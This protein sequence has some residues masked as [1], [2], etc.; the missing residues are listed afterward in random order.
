MKPIFEEEL[1]KPKNIKILSH[2]GKIRGLDTDEVEQLKLITL[3]KSI[4]TFNEEKGCAFST[5]LYNTCRYTYLD[6]FK[7]RQIKTIDNLDV[8]KY[9]NENI[10]DELPFLYKT[11][12]ED[13]FVYKYTIIEM[14]HKYKMKRWQLKI[15]IEDSVDFLK[16]ELEKRKVE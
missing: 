6:F 10:I 11:I 15:L 7:K 4:S 2:L 9:N 8:I 14:L 1:K 3:W 5:H 12:I 13:R 16:K